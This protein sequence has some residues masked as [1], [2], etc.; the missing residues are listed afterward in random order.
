MN[1]LAGT[2]PGS[3]E[4]IQNPIIPIGSELDY[5][6]V[7]GSPEEFLVKVLPNLIGLLLVFGLVVFLF[8]LLWGSLSWILSGGDKAKIENARGRLTSALV[9]VVLMLATFA[10]IK[11]VESFFGVNIL[12]IDIGPLVIE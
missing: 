11:L 5:L 6:L 12:S 4:R 9:G 10:I 8:M 3:N 1:Y 2:I 7:A